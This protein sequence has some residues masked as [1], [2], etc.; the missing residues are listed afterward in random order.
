MT[1]ERGSG[2]VLLKYCGRRGGFVL[3]YGKGINMILIITVNGT[4]LVEC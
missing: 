3:F 4:Q 2:S 1:M